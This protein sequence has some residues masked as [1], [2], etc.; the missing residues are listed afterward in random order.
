VA[1][2]LLLN[3]YQLVEVRNVFVASLYLSLLLLLLFTFGF[4]FPLS[5]VL[6]GGLGGGLDGFD[7]RKTI[8]SIKDE[9]LGMSEKPDY[10]TVKGTIIYIKHDTD[11]FYTACPT[12]NCNKKV[13]ETMHGEF[14]CEK[15]NKQFPEVCGFLSSF[16]LV[17]TLTF[18]FF[19]STSF[20]SYPFS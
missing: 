13:V 7:K 11:P 3:L 4:A 8:S 5:F 19:S 9:M 10:I 15:C 1:L 2:Y 12:P 14:S 20:P 16:L 18:T 6:V 17:R